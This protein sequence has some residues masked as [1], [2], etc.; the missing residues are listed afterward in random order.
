M[1]DNISAF[2]LA[3]KITVLYGVSWI[4]TAWTEV[5]VTTIKKCFTKCGIQVSDT[6][7]QAQPLHAISQEHQTLSTVAG[8]PYNENVEMENLQCC[9]AVSY[10]H[11]DVYKRQI[12]YN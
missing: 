9:N 4:K 8:L 12:Y 11:L 6:D 1:D 2:D 3:K 5:A 7:L 10:T